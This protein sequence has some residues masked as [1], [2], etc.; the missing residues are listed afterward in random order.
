LH[1]DFISY[2]KLVYVFNSKRSAKVDFSC[3][4]PLPLKNNFPM[5]MGMA[6]NINCYGETGNVTGFHNDMDRKSSNAPTKAGGAY[7]KAIY[8][9]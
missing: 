4:N 2:D 1:K 6:I 8:L 5:T 7:P 9:F 3:H